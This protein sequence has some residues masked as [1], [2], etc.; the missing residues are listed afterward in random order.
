MS[1]FVQDLAR[2]KLGH[3]PGSVP[4]ALDQLLL[5]QLALRRE[6]LAVWSAGVFD[7][8]PVAVASI[9]FPGAR[10]R[11]LGWVGAVYTGDAYRPLHRQLPGPVILARYVPLFHITVVFKVGVV[12]LAAVAGGVVELNGDAIV[13]G[14]QVGLDRWVRGVDA[15]D[16]LARVQGVKGGPGLVPVAAHPS[17]VVQLLRLR[18]LK[19]PSETALVS[20]AYPVSPLK[21]FLI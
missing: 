19:H 16:P 7:H 17:H 14:H 2:I 5:V 10:L 3:R 11:S 12:R 4:L 13:V 6:E 1:M 21:P 18:I 9:P 20:E 15:G 8:I